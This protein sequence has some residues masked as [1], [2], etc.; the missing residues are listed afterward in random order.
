MQEITLE[1]LCKAAMQ[2]AIFRG[3]RDDWGGTTEELY[4]A[5]ERIAVLSPNELIQID[6]KKRKATSRKQH[7]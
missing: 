3:S 2:S 1:A 7:A 5:L 6:I 4:E